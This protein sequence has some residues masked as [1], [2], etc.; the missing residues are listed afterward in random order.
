MNNVEVLLLLGTF[1]IIGAHAFASYKVYGDIEQRLNR[2]ED[3]L[4]KK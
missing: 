2:I 3:K 4:N 1:V